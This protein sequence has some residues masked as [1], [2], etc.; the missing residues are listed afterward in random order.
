M[1]KKIINKYSFLEL[2]FLLR[3]KNKKPTSHLICKYSRKNPYQL[4]ARTMAQSTRHPEKIFLR[5]M[6]HSACRLYRTN[7]RK[8]H[9][10]TRV[11]PRILCS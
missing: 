2:I 4:Q 5:Q 11:H 9:L 1:L 10:L 3:N 7:S 6:W 8:L